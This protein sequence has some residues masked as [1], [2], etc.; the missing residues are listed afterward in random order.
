MLNNF[1]QY[2]TI[3]NPYLLY[4][5]TLIHTNLIYTNISRNAN[6]PANISNAINQ[7]AIWEEGMSV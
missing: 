7:Q 6:Y 3:S 1:N 5:L 2:L 4:F